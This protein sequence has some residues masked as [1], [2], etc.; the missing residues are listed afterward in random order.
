MNNK[1]PPDL[2]KDESQRWNLGSQMLSSFSAT[3]S[4]VPTLNRTLR[5]NFQLP[6]IAGP[7]SLISALFTAPITVK[8]S[9][10]VKSSIRR[11][12][13]KNKCQTRITHS[14]TQS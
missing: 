4:L 5:N 1:F 14:K 3:D 2:C 7:S 6:F 12:W 11:N 9:F 8:S 10:S 13:S